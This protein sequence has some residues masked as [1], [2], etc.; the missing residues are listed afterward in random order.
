MV[1]RKIKIYMA[2]AKR[3]KRQQTNNIPAKQQMKIL[4][5]LG[6]ISY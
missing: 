2:V 6:N 4:Y 1:E 5:V 3:G